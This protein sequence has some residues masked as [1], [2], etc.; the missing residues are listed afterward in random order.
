MKSRDVFVSYS[1]ADRECAF[2][3]VAWLEARD[4]G[5][6]IAPRDVAPSADW[7]ADVID[8]ISAARIMVLVFSSST[9]ESVQVRREVE[10][11]VHKGL[12][13]LPFRIEDVL[14]VKSLEYFLS[15]QHWLDAFPPPREPHYERLCAF[16]KG[17]LASPPSVPS[18][19]SLGATTGPLEFARR[20]SPGAADA[21]GALD[22]APRPHCA[23][24]EQLH[25]I[26]TELARYIGP[27]AKHLVRHAAASS[28]DLQQ[29]TLRLSAELDSEQ[30]R[31]TFIGACRLLGGAPL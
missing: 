1:Q 31:Q 21:A 10:R 2:D 30:D 29:L 17:A 16:M 15:S 24:P 5:V 9:N 25:Q 6:W 3:I 20:A 27:V 19:Q 14:P 11:A 8:A 22:L 26:E 4:I 7:A 13:V 28:V 18:R 23:S 12:I